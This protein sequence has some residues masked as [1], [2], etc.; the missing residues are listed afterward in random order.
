MNGVKNTILDI[1]IT[2]PWCK[3]KNQKTKAIPRAKT[4]NQRIPINS[5]NVIIGIDENKTLEIN[6]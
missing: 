1:S 4:P 5:Y 2:S 3:A 6:E